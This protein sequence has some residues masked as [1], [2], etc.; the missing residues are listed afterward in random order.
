MP[1]LY[2]IRTKIINR[3]TE[4]RPCFAVWTFASQ[5]TSF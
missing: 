3:K 5:I 4:N 1:K 2:N